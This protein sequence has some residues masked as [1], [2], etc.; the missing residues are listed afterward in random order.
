MLCARCASA[1]SYWKKKIIIPNVFVS[2]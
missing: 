1:L 2:Y